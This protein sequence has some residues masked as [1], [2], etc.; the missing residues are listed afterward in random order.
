MDLVLVGGGGHCK[1]VLD[2]VICTKHYDKVYISDPDL[3]P[4]TKLLDHAVVV[5]GDECLL[6]LY[7]EGVKEAFVS[8]G[9][10]KPSLLR[11]RL[12]SSLIDIGFH[13]PNIIDPSAVISVN[14]VLGT[15]IF[16]GKTAIVNADVRIGNCSIINTGAIVE[17]ECDIGAF[18][19]ISVNTTLCGQVAVGDYSFIGA[20]STV[21]QGIKIGSN[22]IIGAGSVVLRDVE[23]GEMAVGVIK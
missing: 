11:S 13:V 3:S 2:T 23:D 22:V 15:G 17:H 19:H 9:F 1:S 16:V 4:G 5:G 21:I 10:V 14:A 12:F 7:E 18:T 6:T 20:G 8:V